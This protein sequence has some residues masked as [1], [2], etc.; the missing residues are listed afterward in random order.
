MSALGD[1][2][3]LQ[4]TRG[5]AGGLAGMMLADF[6]AQVL[7]IRKPATDDEP[8][9][10]QT[11]AAADMWQRGQHA[12]DLDLKSA[13]GRETFT[14]L[15]AAADVLL[16]GWR[17]AALA[18]AGLDY[19]TLHAAHPHLVV[20]Q[21]TGFGDKGP[22]ANLPGYEHLAAAL[23]GRMSTFSG[24]ADR[25]GPVYSALQV[26]VHA[27]AQSTLSGILAA[28]HARGEG[29]H[30]RLV[31][32]SLL[33]GMLPYEQGAMIGQQFPER[34]AAMY[35]PVGDEPP[36]PSLYYHPAQAGDARWMQ[37]GNLL[38]HLFDN[39]LLVTDLMDVVAD[40][41]FDPRQLLLRDSAKHEAFRERMLRR[42]QE[43][44]A[45]EWMAACIENGGVVATA[46]QT[47]REAMQDPDI[48]ANGHVIQRGDRQ[49]LG[50]V[51]R[52]TRTPASPG[53]GTPPEADPDA[54]T[55]ACAQLVNRWRKAPRPAPEQPETDTLPLAGIRV[56]EIATIIAAPLG[57]SFLADMGAEVIKIEQVGGDPYRGLAMGV[58]SARVNA[59]K[60]SISLNLKSPDG[61][62]IAAELAAR[63]DILIHNY[64]PGVP[65]RLGIGYEALARDNPGLIY[66]QSNGYGPDGPGAQRPSTHPIPGAAMGGVLLQLGERVPDTLQ[67][68]DGLR[69]WTRR[70]MRANEVNPDPN[71]ALVVASACLLGLNARR[72]NGGQ[73]QRI[74]IDMFGANAYANHDDFVDYPGKPPRQVP[75]EGLHGITPTYRLYECADGQWVFLALVS[76]AERARFADLIEHEGI[77]DA[78]REGEPAAIVDALTD[79]FSRYTADAW[80]ARLAPHG[81]GC[82]RADA[83]TPVEFWLQDA[84]SAAMGLTHE[85]QHPAWG[86]YRRH[87]TNV[88]FNGRAGPAAPPPLAGEHNAAV[89]RELGYGDDEIATLRRDGVIWAE[90]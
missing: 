79:L 38:P 73:G 64:R 56:V 66:L 86:T 15:L 60:R 32:T 45:A 22:R 77:A 84:Q 41:D 16:I 67:D 11:L 35:P 21:L 48:I 65:E 8:D 46:H 44:P 81:I 78:L 27:T 4:L 76:Q 17:P 80:E 63:A 40:E 18:R 87:G 54:A 83:A 59:G 58:G 52:L 55:E 1:L 10:L 34:F 72:N 75:D 85:A 49:E 5:P 33:Q 23:S 82:V 62:K 14:A 50:P 20:C 2:R 88:H 74:L 57:A 89:L 69:L 90:E 19:A 47:T 6:G 25:T 39:Y 70:L 13:P 51:A 36:L 24:I 30:G 28:V 7:H 71:T 37:F 9:E 29:G 53:Q 43:K 12:L 42:I 26:G 3:V 61:Q 68:M 31:Q